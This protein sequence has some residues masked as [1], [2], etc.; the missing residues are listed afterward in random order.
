MAVKPTDIWGYFNGPMSTVKNRPEGITKR[1]K[2]GKV[3]TFAWAAPKPP[4]WYE[5]PKLDRAALRAI[6]PDGFAKAFFRAN[7]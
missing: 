6:T 5:G 3:N 7:Q 4:D 2:S 1:Y